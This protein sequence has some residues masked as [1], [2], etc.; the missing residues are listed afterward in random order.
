MV[1]LRS[2]KSIEKLREN[3]FTPQILALTAII[4]WSTQAVLLSKS[5]H[6]TDFS[7]I[8]FPAL[9]VS[10]IYLLIFKII[11]SGR[12]SV[13]FKSLVSKR[14]LF[15]ISIGAVLFFGYH[16]LLYWG[17]QLGPKVETNLINFLW[18]IFFFILGYWIFNQK[19]L[20]TYFRQKY[21]LQAL[22]CLGNDTIDQKVD[23]ISVEWED[24]L[25]IIFA[26]L[27][28]TI[29]FTQGNIR[30]LNLQYW[31]GPLMGFGAAILWATFSIYLI[32]IGPKSHLTTFICGSM[33]LCFFIWYLRDCPSIF[34]TLKTAIFMGIFPL[35]IAMQCW[36][37]AMREN[38]INDIS[39]LA[40]LAPLFST[41]F[42]FLA[43]VEKFSFCYLIGGTLVILANMNGKKQKLNGTQKIIYTTT[44]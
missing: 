17:L 21:F 29:L 2:L 43:G 37:K 1:I 20:P 19:L 27:G 42:L 7:A 36:E 5:F 12:R 15:L 28:I 16:L 4:L 34:P 38:K 14:M 6:Q 32:L 11:Y 30:E 18:P 44:R 31:H 9:A 8:L 24:I 22:H 10:T 33:I 13:D 40:F 23:A 35:G 39:L 3:L 25:K 26:F 41:L